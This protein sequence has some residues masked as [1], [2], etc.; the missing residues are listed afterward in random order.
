MR[1]RSARFHMDW[2]PIPGRV[3][4][5]TPSAPC[6]ACNNRSFDLFKTL[7]YKHDVQRQNRMNKHHIMCQGVTFWRSVIHLVLA[8]PTETDL[9]SFWW[10][11]YPSVCFPF[12]PHVSLLQSVSAIHSPTGT[13]AGKRSVVSLAVRCIRDHVHCPVR[14]C[15]K[16]TETF[17]VAG[18]CA[19]C[20]AALFLLGKQL[21]GQ[22][23]CCK[24]NRSSAIPL[25]LPTFHFSSLFFTHNCAYLLVTLNQQIHVALALAPQMQLFINREWTAGLQGCHNKT[26][27]PDVF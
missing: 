19:V 6:S 22:I 1:I 25:L 15:N 10:I 7:P 3:L 11:H 12:L 9:A 23:A 16:H 27:D 18:V 21:L 2:W 17:P 13:P 14:E 20:F 4:T 24:L 8:F 5:H 26:R